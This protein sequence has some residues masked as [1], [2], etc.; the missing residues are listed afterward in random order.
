M[1]NKV[2]W[3]VLALIV[4]VGIGWWFFNYYQAPVQTGKE[5]VKI[6]VIGPY[7][8]PLAQYGEA[9]RNGVLLAIEELDLE[10]KG[11]QFVFEDSTYDTATAVGAFKKLTTVD[12]VDLVMDWGAATGYGIAPLVEDAKTPFVAFSVDPD[13]V[14]PSEY[15]IRQFYSPDDFASTLWSYFRKQGYQDIAIVK[16]KLLYYDKIT[17]S[18]QKLAKEGETVTVIDEYQ[19][20]GDNDFRTSLAKISALESAP[21][22]LGVFLAGGQIAQFYKQADVLAV[23]VPTFGA[24][25]F[26]SYSEIADAEGLMDGAV[27][28]NIGVTDEFV[29]RYK[30]EFGNENQVSFAGQSYDFVKILSERVNYTDAD[31][32]LNS[33]RNVRNFQGILGSYTYSE[34]GGDQYLQSPVYIKVIEGNTITTLR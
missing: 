11:F 4:L 21:D 28:G 19:S 17:E 15:I 32:V 29:A 23:D 33:L 20:F 18:L 5:T 12:N 1:N 14:T 2:L 16:L 10:A 9:Y 22:A 27:Y 6:G 30:E 34:A 13:V 26:E 3:A 7:T 8:G 31:S 24:D 25:F